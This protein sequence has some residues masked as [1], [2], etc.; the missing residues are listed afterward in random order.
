M[1]PTKG[2]KRILKQGL[3]EEDLHWKGD[4][5]SLR[6]GDLL[7]GLCRDNE[8]LGSG[9]LPLYGLECWRFRLE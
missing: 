3:K 8:D 7:D 2:E 9:N 4:V 6:L 1:I 5:E